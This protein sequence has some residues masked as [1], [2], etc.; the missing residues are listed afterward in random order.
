MS[1]KPF[2]VDNY[3]RDILVPVNRTMWYRR[4]PTCDNRM[5]YDYQGTLR[6][7]IRTG[8]SC[9]SCSIKQAWKNRKDNKEKEEGSNS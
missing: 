6:R 9:Q 5:S 1:N 8:N 2:S 3:K 7:A 4:C